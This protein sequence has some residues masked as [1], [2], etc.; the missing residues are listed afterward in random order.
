MTGRLWRK[1]QWTLARRRRERELSDE[2]EFHLS[3]D[4]AEAEAAGLTAERA[5]SAAQ[6]ELGSMA[7]V[8][9]DARA[10]WG[11]PLLEQILQDVRYALR[12]L[13]RNPGFA[14]AAVVTLM[15]GVGMTTAIFSTVYGVLLRPLP[16]EAPERLMMLHTV[17]TG[18]TTR[19]RTLSPPNFASLREETR[20]LESVAAFVSGQETLT[21]AGDPQQL[22]GA[23]VTAGF[24]ELLRVRAAIGRT[25]DRREHEPGQDQVAVLGYGVWQRAFGGASSIIGRTIV[26]DGSPRVV[27]G[28][29]PAGFDFPAACAVWLPQPHEDPFLPTSTIGRAFNTWLPVIGRLRDGATLESLHADLGEVGRRLEARFPDSNAGVGFIARPAHDEMVGEVRRPLLLLLGAVALVLSIACANVAGLLLARA[30]RRR[31]EMAVRAS[32]GASRGRLVR[33]LVIE[34]MVLGVGGGALGVLL[35][36]WATGRLAA[37][38]VSGLPRLD[39]IRVD[40]AVLAFAL[41]VTLLAGV[42]AGLLPAIRAAGDSLGGALRTAG[43]SGLAS[44]RGRRLRSGL[45]VGQLALAVV[46]LVGAGLFLRSFL[47]LTAVDPGFRAERVLSFRV[48]LPGT[49]YGS[50]SRVTAYYDQVIERLDAL[51]GVQS[52][53]VASRRPPVGRLASRFRVDRREQPER[54]PSIGIVSISPAYFETMGID[55]VKGRGF[56]LADRMGS[57]PVVI[58]NEAA[59]R[60]FFPG[61]DPVG[62]RLVNFSYNPIEDIASA[63]TIVGVIR[64]YRNGGLGQRARTEAYF[65]QAQA[66]LGRM[67]VAVRANSD[68]LMLTA[69]I[70]AELLAIDPNLAIPTFQ[71]IE[72]LVSDSVARPRF[73]TLVLSLFSAVALL[74]AAVGIFGL[75]SFTVA[76]RTH[77]IGVRLAL[78]A[79]PGSVVRG[80]V[81]E[82][83]ALVA[84]GLGIGL[85]AA[86]A[87]SGLIERQLYGVAPTDPT[88]FV[89]V[90]LVLGGTAVVASLVPALRAAAV[91]PLIA[92][93]TE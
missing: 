10:A 76:Q 23:R 44:Q 86:L 87:L 50:K 36:T 24:F 5:R 66:G 12:T 31:E 59:A 51:P 40:G 82:A 7:R 72:Q 52:V 90:A 62:R 80:I 63:F 53:G 35:A 26:L 47:R 42:L 6:R 57:A 41:A 71:T 81:R 64:D 8:A 19:D 2:L 55:V 79:S 58:L 22:E 1:L 13:A 77:E 61:E 33:Q 49:L 78:G 89:G 30:A 15:L 32:L 9:E 54:E 48:D 68:P 74:L 60:E 65:P 83:L 56:T 45:V 70:R 14:A 25:F 73:L 29:M 67:F 27:I 39:A 84:L 4:A 28:V 75:L 16:F 92:L 88:A 17:I 37:A 18:E 46:L 38:P 21:G 43:R 34:S 69:A 93:R 11:W 85:A 91:D 3:V 20:S